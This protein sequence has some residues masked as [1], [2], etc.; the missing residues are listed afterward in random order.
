VIEQ[1]VV[2]GNIDAPAQI[3]LD[4]FT[5]SVNASLDSHLEALNVTLRETFVDRIQKGEF[6]AFPDLWQQACNGRILYLVEGTE[7]TPW[8]SKLLA[9]IMR[10]VFL[11]PGGRF[12]VREYV[13]ALPIPTKAVVLAGTCASTHPFRL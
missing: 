6:G 8:G 9:A 4:W 12:S 7:I 3:T 13:T 1:V 5:A 11:L 10:E 2:L